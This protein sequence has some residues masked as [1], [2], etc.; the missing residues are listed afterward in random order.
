MVIFEF[1][2]LVLYIWNDS[3]DFEHSLYIYGFS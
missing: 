2:K 1:R 3:V